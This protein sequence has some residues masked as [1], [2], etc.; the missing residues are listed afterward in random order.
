[1]DL[2]IVSNDCGYIAGISIPRD[3]NGRWVFNRQFVNGVSWTFTRVHL[4]QLKV[5]S[6]ATYLVTPSKL[7]QYMDE[8]K[9]F[10]V[11]AHNVGSAQIEALQFIGKKHRFWSIDVRERSISGQTANGQIFT[12]TND[13]IK[14]LAA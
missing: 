1:M 10:E 8:F 5:V 14:E 13:D 2:N 11:R 6:M 4:L 3:C 7:S 9:S 12:I